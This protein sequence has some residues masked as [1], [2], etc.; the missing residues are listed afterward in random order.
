VLGDVIW[1][2]WS[3]FH[4]VSGAHGPDFDP[5]INPLEYTTKTKINEK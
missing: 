1:S 5:D 4:P 2:K 3:A